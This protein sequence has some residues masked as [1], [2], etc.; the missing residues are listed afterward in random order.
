MTNHRRIRGFQTERLVADFLG[1]WWSGATV[2]RGAD[3][4]GDIINMPV[5]VEV[6]SVTKFSPLAWLRQSKARTTKSGKLG[7]VVLRCNGQGNNVSEY[8][9]LLPFHAL[10]ELL[11]KAGYGSMPNEIQDQHIERCSGCDGYIIKGLKCNTC[12]IGYRNASL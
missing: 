1:Q 9:A 12:I 7:I 4:R 3:P 5:D 10:V 8:A 6:K 2:G 11:L